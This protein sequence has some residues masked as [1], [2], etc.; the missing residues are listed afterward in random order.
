[1]TSVGWTSVVMYLSQSDSRDTDKTETSLPSGACR[2]RYWELVAAFV[3]GV[4]VVVAA[5]PSLLQN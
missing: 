4:V 1:M 2:A 3:L 5:R